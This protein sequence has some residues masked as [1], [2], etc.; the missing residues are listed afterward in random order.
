MVGEAF[1]AAGAETVTIMDCSAVAPS[2]SVARKVMTVEPSGREMVAL[3]PV[4]TTDPPTSHSVLDILPS[5]SEAVPVIETDSP[6]V[7]FESASVRS[8]PMMFDTGCLFRAELSEISSGS[9]G[10][11]GLTEIEMGDPE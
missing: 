2:L 8:L 7:P 9:N 6:S 3:V 1:C 10:A 4:A 11:S 5:L